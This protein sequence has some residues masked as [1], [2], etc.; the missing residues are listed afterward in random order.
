MTGT[1]GSSPTERSC[2][3]CGEPFR[4]K[5]RGR[6]GVYCRPACRQRAWALRQARAALA[7]ESGG[8]DSD[9]A[10]GAVP[11]DARGWVR[12]LGQL[13]A[14]LADP[15]SELASRPWEHLRLYDGLGD[16]L[17]ALDEATP[18]GLAWLDRHG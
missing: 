2:A 11:T 3:G 5:G 17:T 10:V 15:N 4:P 18:G 16:A 14:Q 7:R 12:I 13:R 9:A 8:P 1:D 6:P